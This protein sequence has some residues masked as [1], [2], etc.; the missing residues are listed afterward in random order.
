MVAAHHQALVSLRAPPHGGSFM[1]RRLLAAGRAEV[2]AIDHSHSNT[3]ASPSELKEDPR[4]RHHLFI[5][6]LVHTPPCQAS[7]PVPRVHAH[8]AGL[9][10][11][12]MA[13]LQ[14]RA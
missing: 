13:N 9:P 3:P 7:H 6:R 2:V 12:S 11:I 8:A 10:V 14:G 4:R 5:R 1:L